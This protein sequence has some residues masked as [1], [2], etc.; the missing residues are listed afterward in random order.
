MRLCTLLGFSGVSTFLAGFLQLFWGSSKTSV[1]TRHNLLK[2]ISSETTD[3]LRMSLSGVHGYLTTLLLFEGTF[4][5]AAV[6]I[7]QEKS[8][9]N[10]G[11]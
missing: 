10:Y 9:R 3:R 8:L 7:H 6:V 1:S 2:M 11:N 4:K 5:F